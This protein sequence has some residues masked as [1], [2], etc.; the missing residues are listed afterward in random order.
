MFQD[1][2]G[3]MQEMK[4]RPTR[5]TIGPTA[6][7][8]DVFPCT[9]PSSVFL[10][11]DSQELLKAVQQ[12]FPSIFFNQWQLCQLPMHR[13]QVTMANTAL[14]GPTVLTSANRYQGVS[15][16]EEALIFQELDTFVQAGVLRKLQPGE[17]GVFRPMLLFPKPTSGLPLLTLDLC[18][19][20]ALLEPIHSPLPGVLDVIRSVDAQW[21]LFSVVDVVHG[22][23][24]LPIDQ[25]VSK[26]STLVLNT[27]D[28]HSAGCPK[29]GIRPPQSFTP[30]QNRSW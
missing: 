4:R 7:G 23:F 18:F 11:K 5:R 25:E 29:G 13:F 9:A 19:V 16:C 17:L 2:E 27:C 10:V 28:L 6:G 14:K 15:L 24:G 8:L 22:Y 20:N 30:L 21:K 3:H 1:V 26:L 12:E